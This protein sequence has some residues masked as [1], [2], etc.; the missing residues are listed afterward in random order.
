MTSRSRISSPPPFQIPPSKAGAPTYYLTIFSKNCTK[1]LAG[2]RKGSA[3]RKDACA[4]PLSTWVSVSFHNF[5]IFVLFS[6]YRTSF[7]SHRKSMRQKKHGY[8]NEDKLPCNQHGNCL[9]HQQKS[10]QRMAVFGNAE[11]FHFS[12]LHNFI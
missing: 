1:I 7:I 10:V 8:Y 2:G 5:R 6:Y 12:E 11:V 9:S 4:I 3:N